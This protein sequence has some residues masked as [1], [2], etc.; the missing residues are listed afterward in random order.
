MDKVTKNS[1][2][3]DEAKLDFEALWASVSTAF[4]LTLDRIQNYTDSFLRLKLNDPDTFFTPNSLRLVDEAG[5]LAVIAETLDT[6]NGA[7]IRHRLKI[8]NRPKIQQEEK[9]E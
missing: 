5:R 1:L 7:R 4:R 8:I 9:G 2:S 3:H 6:I